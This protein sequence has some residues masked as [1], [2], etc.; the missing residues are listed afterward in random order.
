MAMIHA[1]YLF[2]VIHTLICLYII[3]LFE[4]FT[5]KTFVEQVPFGEFHH[6]KQTLAYEKGYAVRALLSQS[7][8][9]VTIQEYK[10]ITASQSTGE[11]RDIA[12]LSHDAKSKVPKWVEYDR[13]VHIDWGKASMETL[14]C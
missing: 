5:G 9:D 2:L 1:T 7:S 8:S 10:P 3:T 11:Q 6:K 14:M 13:K 4:A 12:A